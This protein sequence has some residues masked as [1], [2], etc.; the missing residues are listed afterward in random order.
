MS[1]LDP[2]QLLASL[3]YLHLL[4]RFHLHTQGKGVLIPDGTE[5]SAEVS[6]L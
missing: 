4:L 2:N 1:G 5:G 6:V 3:T